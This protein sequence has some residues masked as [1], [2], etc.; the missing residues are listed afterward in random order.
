MSRAK[1]EDVSPAQYRAWA[2]AQRRGGDDRRGRARR[3]RAR[4]SSSPPSTRRT[5]GSWPRPGS[6][7]SATR[8]TAP[9]PSCASGPAVLARLR[10]RYRYV[11]VDEFQDTNHAQLELLRLAGRRVRQPHGGGRRRPGHLPL[12]RGRRRQPARLPPALP[13]R[14]RGGAGGEPPL[15][16]ADPRRRGAAHLATTTRYRLEAIAGIDK[17]LRAPAARRPARAPPPLR[18]GLRRGRRRR[19]ARRASGSGR[20]RVPATSPSSCAATATPTPSCAPS[21]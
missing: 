17:R 10:A 20:A 8:S 4:S 18:H 11:L 1:D 3:G 21:T 2:E 13:G 16:P 5:S 7:T 9:S 12:A 6:W 14:P 15:H 19:R